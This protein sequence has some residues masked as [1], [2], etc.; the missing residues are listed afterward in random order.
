M[1]PLVYSQARGYVNRDMATEWAQIRE[2]L[3]PGE[4][5]RD[6]GLRQEVLRLSHQGMRAIGWIEIIAPMFMFLIGRAI[7][8]FPETLPLAVAQTGA[9]MGV[10]AATLAAARTGWGR[11]WP[12]LAGAASG[13][14]TGVA[15]IWSSL[16]IA[17]LVP[18]VAHQIPASLTTVMLVGV[19]VLALR[20][21]HTL[22]LGL[23]MQAVYVAASGIAPAGDA[24]AGPHVFLLMINLLSAALSGVIYRQRWATYHSHQE[25]LQARQDL[26][27]AQSQALLADNAASLGRLAVVMSH[28]LNSPL[29]ALSSAVDSLLL[30]A[31]RKAA[32]PEQADRLGVMEG[33]L[34][35]S[36]EASTARLQQIAGRMQRLTHL[37]R[38][39]TQVA[40]IN[41]LLADAA[42]LAGSGLAEGA[43]IETAFQQVPALV[44]RPRHL[45]AVF[46]S[47]VS[48][49][50][51]AVGAA[52][53]VRISTRAVDASVEVRIEDDGPGMTAEELAAI[54][55]AGFKVSAGR[56]ATGDWSLFGARQVIEDHRG[57]IRL[58]SE[59]GK[60]TT[61]IVTLPY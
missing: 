39:E 56:V 45:S 59:P 35:R 13:W 44:C 9:V 42:A 19:A 46:S 17:E 1:K 52:G 16:R 58:R 11:R 7:T 57:R 8:P 24:D 50:V 33:E 27:T 12:R 49:A 23:A 4:A 22:T 30:L 3:G 14:L 32:A 47:L 29:G 48:N 43:K 10:G 6:E 41:E 31:D 26:G 20:P 61:A 5:E 60:G 36:V 28:E 21:A 34:R 15:L 2:L 37:D 25:A 40:N 53:R 18:K 55:D 51:H 54:F 38:A